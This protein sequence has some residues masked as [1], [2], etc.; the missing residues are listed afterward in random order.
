MKVTDCCL[1][2]QRRSSRAP[3]HQTAPAVSGR[4]SSTQTSP[5]A[6]PR[7][8][9]P[10]AATEVRGLIGKLLKYCEIIFICWTINFVNLMH[11]TIHELKI[12]MKC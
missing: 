5:P 10:S 6:Y 11:R 4:R 1:S 7:G 9:G 8:T 12:P 3:V 2:H